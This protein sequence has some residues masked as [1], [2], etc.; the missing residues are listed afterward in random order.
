[1]GTT[2]TVAIYSAR[3]SLEYYWLQFT[4]RVPNVHEIFDFITTLPQI[5]GK[6]GFVQWGIV[7]R[8]KL[9]ISRI[10]HKCISAFHIFMHGS[11]VGVF[12]R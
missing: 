11:R 2:N 10:K 5:N 12:M 7:E 9:A 8:Y 6:F 1:M 4:K 3:P